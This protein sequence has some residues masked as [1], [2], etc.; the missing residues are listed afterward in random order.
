MTPRRIWRSW[1]EWQLGFELLERVGLREEE[2]QRERRRS[3]KKEE[4]LD[5]NETAPMMPDVLFTCHPTFR[6]AFP[7]G[8]GNCNRIRGTEAHHRLP[9]E[10]TPR[11]HPHAAADLMLRDVNLNL[12]VFWKAVHAVWTSPRYMSKIQKF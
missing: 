10:W 2:I 1:G 12:S 8:F 7:R 4:S 5:T 3:G 9:A 6:T 11:Q